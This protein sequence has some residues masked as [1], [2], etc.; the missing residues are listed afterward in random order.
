MSVIEESEYHRLHGAV[1]D[2]R[3]KTRTNRIVL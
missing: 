2:F 1:S 3:L